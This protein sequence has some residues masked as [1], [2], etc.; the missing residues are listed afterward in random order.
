MLAMATLGDMVIIGVVEA[1][2]AALALA[3]RAP[4]RPASGATSWNPSSWKA[5]GSY[6]RVEVYT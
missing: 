1:R 2:R 4:P 3:L 6:R 5:H